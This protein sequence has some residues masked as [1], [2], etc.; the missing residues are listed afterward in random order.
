MPESP[1]VSVVMPVRNHHETVLRAVNSILKQSYTY[2]ELVIV[3]DHCT[4]T[5]NSI[6]QTIDNQ[7]VKVVNCNGNGI[8]DALNTGIDISRGKYIARMDA[9]DESCSLRLARQ[10]EYLENNPSIGIVSGKILYHGDSQKNKGYYLHVEWLNQVQTTMEIENQRFVDAP[11]A[12]PSVM[13]KS[14]ILQT[15]RYQNGP[16][17]EDYELWL[18]LISHGVQ[19]AKVPEVVLKWYDLRLSRKDNRY[20]SSAFFNLK[21]KY[22]AKHYF[23]QLHARKPI[24]IW[25]VG[26]HV[27]EKSKWLTSYE[28]PIAG[29]ID[30]TRRNTF[31]GKRVVHYQ[32]LLILRRSL[33]LIYVSDRKGKALIRSFLDQH[34]FEEGTNYFFM[35]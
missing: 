18:R 33:I 15:H 8:V 10:V 31:K 6:L 14:E 26:T 34:D 20:S 4:D 35:T 12:H 17:P 16:F 5:C 22:F 13:V 32:N 30:V 21:A 25:G 3:N 9:D 2:F 27:Y 11:V 24:L 23:S 29:Y 7:H 28:L 1:L 19:F